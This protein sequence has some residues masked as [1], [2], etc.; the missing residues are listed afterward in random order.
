MGSRGQTRYPTL[1]PHA[2]RHCFLDLASKGEFRLHCADGV[3]CM[4]TADGR[5]AGFGQTEVLYLA[6]GYEIFYRAGDILN[7]DIGINAMLVEEIY[8][9]DLKALQGGI[10]HFLDLFRAAV[11]PNELVVLDVEPEL[12]RNDDIAAE[13]GDGFADQFF[14]AIRP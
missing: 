8:R 3:Y 7:R 11:Q 10:G 5:A 4:C 9:L 12:G 13:W 1:P 14:V 6:L 2:E